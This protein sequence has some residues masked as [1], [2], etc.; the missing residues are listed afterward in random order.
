MPPSE[1]EGCAHLLRRQDTIFHALAED[2]TDLVCGMNFELIAGLLDG[3]EH[4]TLAARLEPDPG[5]CCVRL[6]EPD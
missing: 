6:R 3:L 5:R 4:P 2:Y 1:A